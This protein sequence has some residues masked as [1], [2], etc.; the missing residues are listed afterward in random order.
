MLVHVE[1]AMNSN[2]LRTILLIDNDTTLSYLFGRFA[3]RGGCQLIVISG[4]TSIEEI[5]TFNPTVIIFS[6][7]ELLD[8][9][10]TVGVELTSLETPIIV[11]TSVTEEAKA[12]ELGAD[13]CMLH[14]LIYDDFQNALAYAAAPK[15]L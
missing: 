2:S 1:Q 3:E 8:K 10:H 7:T 5:R 9:A 4:I 11:C 15:R 12:K 14:P 13:Y 6:S